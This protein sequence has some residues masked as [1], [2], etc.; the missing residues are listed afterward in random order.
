ME[1]NGV[2]T[3]GELAG[4]SLCSLCFVSHDIS[5]T[6]LAGNSKLL[7]NIVRLIFAVTYNHENFLTAKIS[8]YMVYVAHS[9]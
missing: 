8:R 3:I 1:G 6:E 7:L 4:L 5:N 9:H 2:G